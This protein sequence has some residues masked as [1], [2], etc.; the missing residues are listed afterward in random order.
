[1][2]LVSSFVYRRCLCLSARQLLINTR[3]YKS[4]LSYD[5]LFPKCKS[6]DVLSG[7]IKSVSFCGERNLLYSIDDFSLQ[8]N[9]QVMK[10]SMDLF[11]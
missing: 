5:K 7:S 4:N 3:T 11:R 6:L 10:N 8:A 9:Q 2:N 1:M